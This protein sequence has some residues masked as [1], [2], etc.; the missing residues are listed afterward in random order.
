MLYVPL[1]FCSYEIFGLLV[2]GAIPS[3]LSEAELWRI[4]LAYPEA[5]LEERPA[6]DFK[7]QIANGSIVP[8]LKEV[9]L[10]FFMVPPA[11]SN[12]LI[13]MSIFKK[14]HFAPSQQQ[15]PIPGRYPSSLPHEREV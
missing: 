6:P 13:D 5:L 7:V 3:A 15:C 12:V 9:L 11:M 2:T 4:L 10:R 1:H 8:M 14:S